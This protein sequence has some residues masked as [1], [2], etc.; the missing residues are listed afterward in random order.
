MPMKCRFVR[1]LASGHCLDPAS[2]QHFADRNRWFA[3]NSPVKNLPL[4]S[5]TYHRQ[6][7]DSLLRFAGILL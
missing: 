3:N 2:H 4:Y 7:T 1:I 6:S 5:S